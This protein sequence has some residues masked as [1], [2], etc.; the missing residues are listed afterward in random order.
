VPRPKVTS[1]IIEIVRRDTPAVTSDRDTLFRLVRTAFGQ[2]RKML[3]RSL[4]GVV[5]DEQFAAAN[6]ESTRRPEEL[7]VF[8]WGRLAD[9]M[10]STGAVVEVHHDES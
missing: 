4:H 6:I 1:T 9:V 10:K 8:D 3:R 2:R 5:T 7:S